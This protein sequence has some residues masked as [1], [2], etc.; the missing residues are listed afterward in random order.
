MK[1]ILTFINGLAAWAIVLSCNGQGGK[2]EHTLDSFIS[3]K[4][5]SL[6][7]SQ[8]L[9]GIFIG[10]L[11]DGKR[12]YYNYGFADPDKKISFDSA[13][14]F[15]IGSIT[16][17]FTAFIVEKVLAGK[18]ISDSISILEYLPDSVKMNKALEKI[19]FLNLLNHTSGLP[20]LPDNIDL[21]TR[22]PYENYDLNKLFAFLKTTKPKPPGTYEY[23][24]LGFGLAGVLSSL[25]NK[26][27]Y[28]ALLDEHVF[29]PLNMLKPDDSIEAIDK[30]SKGFME[31]EAVDYWKFDALAV[32][33]H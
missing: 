17:T 9:P 31:N 24:N 20:R 6:Y 15:E 14:L 5:D 1:S 8:N 29:F 3:N 4:A 25:I 13:T 10:V 21:S 28:A 27:S 2:N 7:K 33:A 16:K 11:N 18:G 23:S 22:Q 30:K 19:S 26:K 32:L 12:Q